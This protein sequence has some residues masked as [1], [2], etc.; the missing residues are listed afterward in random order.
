MR[1]YDI[2]TEA[3]A[4][5]IEPGSTI[6]LRAGGHITPLARDTLRERRVTIVDAMAERE[7]LESLAP[8]SPV[9]RVAIGGDHT[10]VAMKR[11]LVAYLRGLGLQVSDLGT[12]TTAPVDYPDIAASVAR[13]I[14]EGDA[15]AGIVIDGAG[16]GSAIAANKI[17]GIRAA[18]CLNDTTARYAREHNGTNVLTLGSTLVDIATARRIVDTWLQ[19][20]MREPRYIRRL[21][22]IRRLEQR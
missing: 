12:D 22:K 10:A 8:I 19:T 6:A 16:I 17:A 1:E 2:I 21:E 14:V 7:Q 4:R 15:D 18:M 13:A 3:D 20:A 9:K 5:V 11:D